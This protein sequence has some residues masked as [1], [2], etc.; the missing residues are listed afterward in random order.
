MKRVIPLYQLTLA[1]LLLAAANS[2][3]A[4]TA[5]PQLDADTL[6]SE[7]RLNKAIDSAQESTQLDKAVREKLIELY[8]STIE[9]RQE[10]QTHNAAAAEFIRDREE[11]PGK[12]EAIMEDF[13]KQ[14]KSEVSDRQAQQIDDEAATPELEQR[15]VALKAALTA[16]N[17]R[18][19]S[20]NQQLESLKQRPEEIS[21]QIATA[22][23]RLQ[24]VDD[25]MKYPAPA[26]QL[27][28]LSEAQHWDLAT[29]SAALSSEIEMLN[30]ELLGQSTMIELLKTQRIQA[31][32]SYK[33]L[34]TTSDLLQEKLAQ[35]RQSEIEQARMKAQREKEEAAGKHLLVRELAE[36]N[37]ILSKELQQLTRQ[38]ERLVLDKDQIVATTLEIEE[39][40]RNTRDKIELAGLSQV[41]GQVL[42][43]QRR[44]LPDTKTFQNRAKLSQ[45]H[46]TKAG[47]RQINDIQER[48]SLHDVTGYIGELTSTLEP[49]E[50]A[51]IH[52]DMVKLAESRR[53]LLDKGITLNS[54][55][56]RT[57][58]EAERA[59]RHF[60]ETVENYQLFLARHLLWV[61][62]AGLPSLENIPLSIKQFK[63]IFN[64]ALWRESLQALLSSGM[65]SPLL[66]VGLLIVILL[67]V[68]AGR[69]RSII[70]TAGR[71]VGKPLEDHF[72]YTFKALIASLLYALPW[73]L[74]LAL[75]GWQLGAVEEAT[76]FTKSLSETLL[77]I[78]P[79][80][81]FLRS[82]TIICIPNGV[83]AIHF[84]WPKSS[85]QQL[86]TEFK[87]F[88][89][90]FLPILFMAIT[91]FNYSDIPLEKGLGRVS[92]TLTLLLLGIFFYRLFRSR[93]A[94]LK[95]Q[96]HFPDFLFANKQLLWMSI[97][98]LIP[99]ALLILTLL[100]YIFTAGMLIENLLSTLWYAL[101]LVVAHQLAI[102]W[103]VLSH[104]RL[105]FKAMLEHH[106]KETDGEEP[107]QPEAEEK[108]DLSTLTL[109]SRKLLDVALII[110]A[111]A[112]L[113]LIW[114]E[115]LPAFTL[116]DNV[117]L[118]NAT[119]TIAGV[120]QHVAITLGT[121][122]TTII[123]IIITIVAATNIPA[124]L[125]IVLRQSFGVPAGN[126]YA[127][128]TL[129]KYLIAS[130]GVIIVF[131][132]LGGSWSQL[133]WLV[134]ALGVGIGFGLQ[135]IIANF[136]CGIIILFERPIR[137]GDF[138]TVGESSGKVT[139]IRIRA[140]TILTRD[141]QELLVPNKE[142]ITGR[143]LN[144]SLSDQTTRI[145]VPVGVAYGS[146]VKTAMELMLQAARENDNVLDEP[147]PFVTFE[148]FGDS[149]L[150]L[151]LRCFLE[152]VDG[153]LETISQLHERINEKINAANIEIAFPQQ[154]VH[155]DFSHPLDVRIMNQGASAPLSTRG[156]G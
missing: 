24:E 27:P 6:V 51:A 15:L 12:I 9:L 132:T 31:E 26:D 7:E 13:R 117:T 85:V 82:F 112:G 107:P 90:I 133:Q 21:Q 44:N 18:V 72:L 116:L 115:V 153:L 77:K 94:V 28:L 16:A 64:P 96:S 99:A 100:G 91:S 76:I 42:L 78:A 63:W 145:I 154:D 127:I 40:F 128:T 146:D 54:N 80:F 101:A 108:F 114:S 150:I 118:W 46:M 52:S 10:V 144:W 141:R 33:Q 4:E 143:L 50:A 29:R 39:E 75:I 129:I 35:R 126:R 60:L 151:N 84:N 125:E 89:I 149:S 140:T 155:L 14:E 88:T 106:K 135:E 73:P 109:Q 20:L 30:Q 49:R 156:E 71:P 87:H 152:S 67:Q 105:A 124:L 59:Y 98:L 38:L 103:L 95:L 34:S 142:F 11:S 23:Q 81:Y 119:K 139:R 47:L 53:S 134:A 66:I 122:F 93:S 136:I 3:A 148:S 45:R 62:N 137:V 111:I 8:K 147:E 113:W 22:T 48:K 55:Y 36:K 123:I 68:N 104:R 74:L 65:E 110:A 102:R 1:L 121:V 41:F 5:A 70:E 138:V 17:N 61:R 32:E 43:D 130:I 86:R 19:A 58:E 56:I 69:L 131:G 79:A 2:A 57:L 83:A 37:T 97:L 120:E 25:E 92:I